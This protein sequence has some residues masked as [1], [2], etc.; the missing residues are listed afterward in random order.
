[1]FD[2]KCFKTTLH[3]LTRQRCG[4]VDPTVAPGRAAESFFPMK[5]DITGLREGTRWISGEQRR[6]AAWRCRRAFSG[7]WHGAKS[8]SGRA[9]R[10]SQRLSRCKTGRA[11]AA[12]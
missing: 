7:R 4:A 2:I 10:L 11:D 1:M 8:V 3:I 6:E 12:I 5:A 9:Q